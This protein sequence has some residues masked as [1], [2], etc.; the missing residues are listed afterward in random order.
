V[1]ATQ[2]EGEERLRGE[3]AVNVGGSDQNNVVVTLAGSITVK[4]T[5]HLLP[6]SDA[7]SAPKGCAVALRPLGASAPEERELR[8]WASA[9]GDFEIPGVLPGHYRVKIGCFGGYISSAR[10]G[11]SDLL[12][13]NELSIAPGA[14]PPPIEVTLGTDGGTVEISPP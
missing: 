14:A 6:A 12:A 8:T 5:L 9:E 13:R 11:E 1:R 10:F 2:G 3:Q 7:Q 4:G